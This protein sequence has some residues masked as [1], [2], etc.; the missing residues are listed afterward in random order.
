[1]N[2]ND[3]HAFKEITESPIILDF[4]ECKYLGEIH[5]M[6]KEKF[7]LPEYYGENWDALWDFLRYLF[8]DK[9][10]IVEIYNLDSLDKKLQQECKIM[11][12]V[13]DRV[14]SIQNNFS[15]KIIS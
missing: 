4:S 11:L 9:K 13:F 10:Y 7:G 3:Y 6:L 15:Y 2:Y 8:D 14:S 5:L 12:R 1:M